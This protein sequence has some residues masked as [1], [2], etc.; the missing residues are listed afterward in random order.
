[1]SDPGS[2][3]RD[4]STMKRAS[5]LHST[6]KR[7]SVLHSTMKRASALHSTMKRASV[8]HSTMKRASVNGLIYI[9][10]TCH[11]ISY[12]FNQNHLI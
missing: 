6:M 3:Q 4:H 10:K 2:S 7:A 11:T 1:M 5:V 9:G 8:L 12:M